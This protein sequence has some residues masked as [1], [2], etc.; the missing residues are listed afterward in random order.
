MGTM[1]R[2]P[3]IEHS[4]LV[5]VKLAGKPVADAS[6]QVRK[7]TRDSNSPLSASTVYGMGHTR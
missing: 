7:W 1:V 4:S 3:G 2:M 6:T 5:T